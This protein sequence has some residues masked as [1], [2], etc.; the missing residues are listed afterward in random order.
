MFAKTKPLAGITGSPEMR[1]LTEERLLEEIK[2]ANGMGRSVYA[3]SLL[4]LIRLCKE[5]NHWQPIESAPKDRRIL[6]WNVIEGVYESRCHEKEGKRDEWPHCKFIF[7]GKGDLEIDPTLEP[8]K[9]T[10]W[11]QPTHWQ[12]LP[13]DPK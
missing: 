9:I 11:S 1:G 2:L 3:A 6:V 12:E 8:L 10:N 4:E 13:P 7:P 5:L